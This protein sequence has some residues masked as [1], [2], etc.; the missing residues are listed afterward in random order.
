[1][2]SRSGAANF[3]FSQSRQGTKKKIY[4]LYPDILGDRNFCLVTPDYRRLA[5]NF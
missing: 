4:S 5:L 3:Y 1:M 2:I